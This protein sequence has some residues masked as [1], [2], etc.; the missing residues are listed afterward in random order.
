MRL[1]QTTLGSSRHTDLGTGL[2]ERYTCLAME[3]KETSMI[4]E[5]KT[6][7]FPL[8]ILFSLDSNQIQVGRRIKW[9]PKAGRWWGQME[10]GKN[11]EEWVNQLAPLL[12]QHSLCYFLFSLF[13]LDLQTVILAAIS[14][15]LLQLLYIHAQINLVREHNVTGQCHI[16]TADFLIYVGSCIWHIAHKAMEFIVL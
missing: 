8:A 1:K 5:G 6:S 15:S 10:R 2:S 16:R 4:L 3:R 7:S 11:A 14:S 13:C 9:L 12:C